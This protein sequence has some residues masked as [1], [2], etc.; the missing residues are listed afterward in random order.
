M[1]AC[2]RR[3]C[4]LVS[5]P[6]PP[7]PPRLSATGRCRLGWS[8]GLAGAAVP[9]W[10]AGLL[11]RPAWPPAPRGG[12]V[13]MLCRPGPCSPLGAAQGRHPTWL[14]FLMQSPARPPSLRQLGEGVPAA[15]L[16]RASWTGLGFATASHGCQPGLLA[17]LWSPH[18]LLHTSP[19]PGGRG[20]GR[21]GAA[22]PTVLPGLRTTGWL[23]S[24]RPSA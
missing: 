6:T 23:T 9:P 19:S 16:P 12:G 24:R 10:G 21:V 17:S 20:G 13:S 1:S 14:T 22:C 18:F 3:A 15:P 11:C 2:G 5:S 7:L 4:P 8:A